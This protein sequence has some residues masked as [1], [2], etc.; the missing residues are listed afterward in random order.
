MVFDPSDVEIDKSLFEP[1]D[2]S[3]SVYGSDL[4]E[5]VLPGVPEA[6]GQGFVMTAYVDSDHA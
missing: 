2:W 4:R 6:R 5:E 1:Q 3:S